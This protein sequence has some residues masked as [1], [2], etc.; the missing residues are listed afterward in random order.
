MIERWMMRFLKRR[1][2]VVFYLDKPARICK[3]PGFCW[4]V[5]YEETRLTEE[6]EDLKRSLPYALR[7]TTREEDA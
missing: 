5:I 3:A 6:I 2:W 1:G 7:G 4:M